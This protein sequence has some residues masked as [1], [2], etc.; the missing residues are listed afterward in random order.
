MDTRPPI[1]TTVP[2]EVISVSFNNN[3]SH[4]TLGLNSGYAGM[5]YATNTFL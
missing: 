2:T 1:E 4:F 5:Y 3:C